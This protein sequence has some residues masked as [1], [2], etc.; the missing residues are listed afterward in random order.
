[1]DE[2]T[3]RSLRED[4]MWLEGE[5]RRHLALARYHEEE[6]QRY[7]RRRFDVNKILERATSG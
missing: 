7:N 1:M 4:A 6:Y 5:A 3:E 2:K